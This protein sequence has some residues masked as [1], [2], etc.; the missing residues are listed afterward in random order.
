M[1]F[2]DLPDIVLYFPGGLPD[3]KPNHMVEPMLN[4][5]D[6]AYHE[7]VYFCSHLPKAE[8]IPVNTFYDLEPKAV[9]ILGDEG[10]APDVKVPPIYPVGPLI[11]DGEDVDH[12]CLTWLD[13]QPSKSVVFLCFGSRGSFSMKQVKEIAKGLEMS[14]QRFL[15]VVKKPPAHEE[16]KQID[17]INNF[18][19]EEILPQGF[20]KRVQ[21]RG[22]VVKSL[23]PQVSHDSVGGFVTHSGWNSVLEAVVAGVTMVAWP[24][25]AEQHINRNLLIEY[26]EMSI[27]MD[28]RDEDGFVSGDKLE[29]RVR[30]LMDSERGKE[31]RE[32]S[33]K[34]KESALGVWTESGSTLITL[35]ELVKKWK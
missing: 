20:L 33:R 28:Q 15:W 34:L 14:G 10:W 22:M 26:M 29:R 31:L 4:R 24:F 32:K 17:H 35:D 21:D 8:G 23:A 6:L 13:R 9:R 25:Y 3:L 16:S 2:K 30:E 12:E 7:F 11:A 5:D 1:S 19:L 18:D 27:P